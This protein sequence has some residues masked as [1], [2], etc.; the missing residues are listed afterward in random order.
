VSHLRPAP[1][2]QEKTNMLPS[3]FPYLVAISTLTACGLIALT[4]IRTIHGLD[5]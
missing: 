3:P 5:A 2:S 1:A 4:L